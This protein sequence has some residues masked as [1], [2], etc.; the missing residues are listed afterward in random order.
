MIIIFR[1]FKRCV[2][3]YYYI[4]HM[5]N[6]YKINIKILDDHRTDILS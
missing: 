5:D 4:D 6:F 2:V 3:N 1:N